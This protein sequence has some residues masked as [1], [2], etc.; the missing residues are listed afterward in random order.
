M[1]F[2][3][4]NGVTV[5]VAVESVSMAYVDIGGEQA[6][7]PSGELV[8]GPSTTKREWRMTTAAPVPVSELDAWVGLIEGKGH[9]WTFDADLYSARGRG[10]VAGY[11]DAARYTTDK[12]YGAASILV[13][14]T[15]GTISWPL[16]LGSSWT[17]AY[18]VNDQGGSGWKHRIVRSDASEW[19]NGA[20][21]GGGFGEA[22][23]TSGALVLAGTDGTDWLLDDVVALPYAVPDSWV[24]GLYAQHS[25]SAWGALPRVVA[26]GSFA[27]SSVT[28]RGKVTETKVIRY[29]SAGALTAGHT[30]EFTLREV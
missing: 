17:L 13:T 15:T 10:P 21:G 7:S 16:G 11:V 26:A 25:A 4:L 2:L 28:V 12:K 29:A 30:L 1:A 27:P 18:W 6:R 14:N 22:T 5:R 20:V 3:T 9:T 19:T 24:A 8:G 23:V